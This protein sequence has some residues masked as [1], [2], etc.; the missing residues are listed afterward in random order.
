MAVQL[1]T[2]KLNI[3]PTRPHLVP[4]PRLVEK[5]NEGAA[6]PLILL[7]APPGF[8][9][10]TLLVDWLKQQSLPVAWYSLDERDNDLARFLTYAISAIQA[11]EAGFGQS[12]LNRIRARRRQPL[13]SVITSLCNELAALPREIVLVL[14]DYHLI[15]TQ[16]IHQAMA[17]L[18]DH[19]PQPL[20]LVIATRADPPLPL[21]RLRARAQLLELRAPDLRFSPDEAAAFLNQQMGLRLTPE[22][23]SALDARAEG[24]IAGLQLAALSIQGH[25]NV[26]GFVH[27]FTGSHRFILDYLAE[28]VLQHQS[29]ETQ[30]FLLQTCLLDQIFAPLADAVTRRSDS[31]QVLAQLERANLFIVPLDDTRQWYRY[32]HLFADLLAIRL[33]E[34]PAEEI[35]EIHRRASAWYALNGFL[36]EAVEHALTAQDFEH[37]VSLIEQAAPALLLR[38]EDRTLRAWL[39]ALPPEIITPETRSAYGRRRPRWPQAISNWPKSI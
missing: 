19:F 29:P 21:A 1:L 10:T 20:H 9:K 7:S 25:Q 28:E 11:I 14:D 34:R 33:R 24:W 3:P 39:A 15:E 31:A 27:A 23:I 36:N 12:T 2:T 22:Q 35:A 18:L 4:R 26:A 32:H 17:F 37:A 16:V 5:L 8:G 13:E 30:N 38:S 6:R